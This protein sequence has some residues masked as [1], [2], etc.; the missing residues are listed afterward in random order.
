MVL[1]LVVHVNTIPSYHHVY[2]ENEWGGWKGNCRVP[3]NEFLCSSMR[4]LELFIY[5]F[6]MKVDVSSCIAAAGVDK[7]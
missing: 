1:L 5:L 6:L 4:K 7:A 2:G 3:K